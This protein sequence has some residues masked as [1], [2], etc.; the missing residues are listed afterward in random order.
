MVHDLAN[1]FTNNFY[2]IPSKFKQEKWLHGE[3]KNTIDEMF[4]VGEESQVYLKAYEGETFIIIK[5]G[6][7]KFKDQLKIY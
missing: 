3:T 4:E 2:L 7:T 6:I 5:S 1:L